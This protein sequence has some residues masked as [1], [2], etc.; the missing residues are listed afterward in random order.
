MVWCLSFGQGHIVDTDDDMRETPLS[1]DVSDEEGL[2]ERNGGGNRSHSK[3]R[4]S[5][6][7]ASV[8]MLVACVGRML[9]PQVRGASWLR[10]NVKPGDAPSLCH[11]CVSPTS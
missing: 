11:A 3:R 1:R 4:S 9:A 2:E 7:F 5:H 10:E 8:G 6:V